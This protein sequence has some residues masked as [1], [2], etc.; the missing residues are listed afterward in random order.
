MGIRRRVMPPGPQ[1]IALVAL[2]QVVLA[3]PQHNCCLHCNASHYLLRSTLMRLDHGASC[4]LGRSNLYCLRHRA[5]VA[6]TAGHRATCSSTR[7]AP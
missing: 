3:A 2:Q 6:C 1:Q 7:Q 4:C 5:I